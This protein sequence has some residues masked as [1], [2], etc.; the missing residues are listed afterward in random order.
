MEKYYKYF[1]Y[2]NDPNHIK[3]LNNQ[4]NKNLC[5]KCAQNLQQDENKQ[6]NQPVQATKVKFLKINPQP[7]VLQATHIIEQFEKDTDAGDL[8]LNKDP[9]VIDRITPILPQNDQS[10]PVPAQ[11]ARR[12]H[13]KQIKA[14]ENIQI[15]TQPEQNQTNIPV[16]RFKRSIN[17]SGPYTRKC[18]TN[19]QTEIQNRQQVSTLHT[20]SSTH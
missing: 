14:E 18:S 15:E 1:Q 2:S 7:E 5:T 13:I 16:Q 20:N 9:A 4:N 6:P 12:I 3:Y 17:G 8:T 11:I 19:Q 10:S